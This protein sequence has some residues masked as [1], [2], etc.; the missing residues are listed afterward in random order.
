LNSRGGGLCKYNG[1]KR[2]KQKGKGRQLINNGKAVI[3]KRERVDAWHRH[4]EGKG[5]VDAVS[6]SFTPG[7]NLSLMP[8]FCKEVGQTLWPTEKKGGGGGGYCL[9]FLGNFHCGKEWGA[10]AKTEKKDPQSMMVKPS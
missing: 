7:E 8:L 3:R 5:K 9:S 1:R 10:M 6:L 2:R 4:G